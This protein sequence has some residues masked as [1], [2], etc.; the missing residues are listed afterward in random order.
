MRNRNWVPLAA[1]SIAVVL[2]AIG[3]V[4]LLWPTPGS[5]GWFAYQPEAQLALYPSAH[6]LSTVDL[7]GWALIA[8]SAVVASGTVGWLLGR[9]HQRRQPFNFGFVGGAGPTRF[10][11]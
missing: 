7:R 1:F 6:L 5:F 9:R 10:N 2:A 11:Q 4:L 8:L 3:A